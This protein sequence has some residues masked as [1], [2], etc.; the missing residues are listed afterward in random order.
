MSARTPAALRELASRYADF[1][2][3]TETSW[4][5]IC[6]TAGTGR[7]VFAERLAIVAADKKDATNQLRSWLLE[8]ASAQV[9]QGAV[10]PG[11]RLRAALILGTDLERLDHLLGDASTMTEQR[12][13]TWESRWRSWGVDPMLVA[14]SGPD[15]QAQLERAGVTL[16]VVTGAATVDL[17]AVHLAPASEWRDL[18][19]A[20]AALFVRGVRIDWQGW[21][22]DLKHR[23]VTLPTYPFQRQRF[24]IEAQAGK[25]QA[26]GVATGRPL[27]G[28]RLRAAGVRGQFETELSIDGALSWI[29]EHVVGG[30]PVFPGTAHIELMLEAGAE[31]L[32]AHELAL[33][34]LILQAPLVVDAPRAVQTVVEPESGGRSRVRIYTENE[35]GDWETMSEAWIG[36]ISRQDLEAERMDLAEIRS[37]LRP[38]D[39]AQFLCGN[40]GT[41]TSSSGMRFAD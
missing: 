7:A 23:S 32:G 30:R 33:E 34:D 1:L 20:V 6:H 12:A 27:L 19:H 2:E 16:A 4:G 9:R 11:D 24:W 38:T 22:G 8:G 21:E 25:S 35:A 3:Q 37:R 26:Q 39:V 18:A 29:D 28:R 10:R 17:P 14:S 15:L 13:K 31:T 36:S 41:R 5:E 40:G